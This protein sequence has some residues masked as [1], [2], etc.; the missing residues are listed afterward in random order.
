MKMIHLAKPPRG[1]F[2]YGRELVVPAVYLS[3]QQLK[4]PWLDFVE[5]VLTLLVDDAIH[6]L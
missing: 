3:I 6:M 2:F 1:G 5:V 4:Q